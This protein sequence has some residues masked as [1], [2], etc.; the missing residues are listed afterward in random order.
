[1]TE[2]T[3]HIPEPVD[4][5]VDN[6]IVTNDELVPEE[7]V[8]NDNKDDLIMSESEDISVVAE[9]TNTSNIQK[10][11][12]EFP[13]KNNSVTLN[14][15]VSSSFNKDTK[16]NFGENI[17]VTPVTQKE[18][19]YIVNTEQFNQAGGDGMSYEWRSKFADGL[20]LIHT[21]DAMQK[22]IDEEE[23]DWQQYVKHDDK[24]IRPF[25]PKWKTPDNGTLSGLRAIDKI[26]SALNQGS[27]ITIPC[28]ASGI[29]LTI[30][31]PT[32]LELADNFDLIAN[33]MIELGKQTGGGIFENTQVYL[34]KNLIDLVTKLFYS[35][36]VID[37]E[38]TENRTL[39]EMLLVDDLET[40]AWAIGACMY[41]NGY[42]FDEP[43]VANTENCNEVN[44][45]LININKM[46][47]VNNNKLT[48]WQKEF[49]SNPTTKHSY[50]DIMKYRLESAIGQTTHVRLK[51][52]PFTVYLKTPTIQE[53]IDGGY[54]WINQLKESIRDIVT[55]ANDTKLNNMLF[56]RAGLTIARGYGH[57]VSAIVFDDGKKINNREDLNAVINEICAVPEAT[58]ALI[59][60]INKHI[61]KVAV[62]LVAFPRHSCPKC[63]KPSIE[64]E[65]EQ[66]PYLIPISALK[67]FFSLRDRKL[68]IA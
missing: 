18:L 33:E 57:Y 67:L 14:E 43:C 21:N 64:P 4:S 8:D 41:P 29:W 15:P 26:R 6:T 45:Q 37:N 30:K 5:V 32:T 9:T 68:G 59:E 38:N 46:F 24:T 49:M 20:D 19:E 54:G 31:A 65:Y 1:M 48:K 61:A 63:K 28:W 35:W 17:P 7:E 60:E 16:N 40:I 42:P 2:K 51:D 27:T 25:R 62:T 11:T 13:I 39:E 58:T 53:Y 22:A 34:N 44:S 52:Y 23:Q 56:E 3:I 55:N 50:D 12:V 36:N 10:D 47:F 66:H